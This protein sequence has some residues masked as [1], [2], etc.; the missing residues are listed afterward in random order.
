MRFAEAFAEA[1]MKHRA[2]RGWRHERHEVLN[3]GD[4]RGDFG[5]EG[6]RYFDSPTDR[7]QQHRHDQQERPRP[8]RRVREQR[9]DHPEGVAER[10]RWQRLGREGWQRSRESGGYGSQ[11]DAW[12]SGAGFAPAGFG[13]GPEED[14]GRGGFEDQDWQVTRPAR[15]RG[16]WAGDWEEQENY[17]GRGPRDYAPSDERVRDEVCERLTDDRAVDASD[18]SVRVQNG[19]VTLTGTVPT[20]EHKRRAEECALRVRGVHDVFN[21]LRVA[22]AGR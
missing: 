3:R 16:A 1:G 20:R 11:Y 17:S 2:H 22:R 15:G 6:H 7:D 21:Q 12:R 18:V 14:P 4:Y 5:P 19:E 9:Q 10:W 13:F 8:T